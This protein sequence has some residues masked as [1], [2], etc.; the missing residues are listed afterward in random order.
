METDK[1][2][3]FTGLETVNQVI[4][5]HCDIRGSNDLK[6]VVDFFHDRHVILHY[7]TTPEL[8][9]LVVLSHQWLIDLFKDVITVKPKS[10][11]RKK[12]GKGIKDHWKA[13]GVGNLHRD[14]VKHVWKDR[15]PE[16]ETIDSLLEMLQKFSVICKKQKD[17][18]EV[19]HL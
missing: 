6:T 15:I 3:K 8:N 12:A 16:E 13:L 7:D 14:L 18:Q 11:R 10:C 2:K 5:K 19:S 1:G 17:Q 4:G 9:Q